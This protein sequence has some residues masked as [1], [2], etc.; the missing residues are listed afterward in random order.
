MWTSVDHAPVLHTPP[1]LV[2]YACSARES[3]LDQLMFARSI[4][5]VFASSTAPHPVQV[6]LR[7]RERDFPGIRGVF[8]HCSSPVWPDSSCSRAPSTRRCPYFTLSSSGPRNPRPCTSSYSPATQPC[9][10]IDWSLSFSSVWVLRTMNLSFSARLPVEFTF[11]GSVA[12][13]S[14]SFASFA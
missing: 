14:P 13:C 12:S 10:G 6:H 8:R 3:F 7:D 5:R 4:A 1:R 11:L 9:I 2:R